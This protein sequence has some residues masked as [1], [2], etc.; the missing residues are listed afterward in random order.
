MEWRAFKTNNHRFCLE[1]RAVETLFSIAA[2][3]REEVFR[4]MVLG[5]AQGWVCAS[6]GITMQELRQ[7]TSLVGS[8]AGMSSMVIKCMDRPGAV[9][10][11]SRGN[12][13]EVVYSRLCGAGD[14]LL[15]N[16]V[17]EGM[18]HV[19]MDHDWV[20]PVLAPQGE[21]RAIYLFA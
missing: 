12:V 8:V 11:V 14:E 6:C 7:L 5:D 13:G 2:R 17:G 1:P 4:S 16:M 20:V 3:E 15:R 21:R 19:V 10:H 9:G 18:V